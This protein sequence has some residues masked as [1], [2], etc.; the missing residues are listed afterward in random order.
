MD[1]AT[2]D[3]GRVQLNN[4]D[5]ANKPVL[6]LLLLLENCSFVAAVGLIFANQCQ[7]RHTYCNLCLFSAMQ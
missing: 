4:L 5:R 7:L 1:S 2:L 3:G 6:P